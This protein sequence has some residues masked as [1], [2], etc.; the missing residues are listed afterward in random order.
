MID[1]IKFRQDLA[2]RRIFLGMS[3]TDVAKRSKVPIKT[4]RS[5]LQNKSENTCFSHVV[6][7]AEALGVS[8]EIKKPP[9]HETREHQA[10]VKAKNIIRMVQATSGL[11]GQAVGPEARAD[12]EEQTVHE[13][14]AGSNRTLWG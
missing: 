13:M 6:A 3:Y 9:I 14:L 8:I 5:M 11:E 7:I 12:M 2:I 10:R 1:Y 4:V